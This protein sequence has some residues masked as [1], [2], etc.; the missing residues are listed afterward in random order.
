MKGRTF[1]NLLLNTLFDR[2][3]VLTHWLKRS[4]PIPLVSN[5]VPLLYSI[6]SLRVNIQSDTWSYYG[7]ECIKLSLNSLDCIY[8]PFFPQSHFHD[9][10]SYSSKFKWIFRYEIIYC[11]MIPSTA[12]LTLN[13]SSSSPDDLF[14]HWKPQVLFHSQQMDKSGEEKV[15]RD[16]TEVLRTE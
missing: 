11:C 5:F 2:F 4:T 3:T 6:L 9:S 8:F 7:T 15:G 14:I 12:T 13:S 1:P 16:R 10:G